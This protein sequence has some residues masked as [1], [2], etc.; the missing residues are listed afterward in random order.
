MNTLNNNGKLKIAVPNKGRLKEPTLEMLRAIGL[1][2]EV[3]ER[4]LFSRVQNFNLEILFISAG[5]I[6]EYVQDGVA[7]LG[8]TGLDLVR[9]KNARVEILEKLGYGK[10]NLTLA[11]PEGKNIRTIEDLNGKKIATTF[12]NLTKKFVEEN[13]ILA[14]IIEVDG[15]VEITP[16]LGLVDAISDLASSGSTM[17]LNKLLP[18]KTLLESEAVLIA[19]TKSLKKENPDVETLCLRFESV[20]TAR[21]KRY[22]MMNAPE[23]T[24]ETIKKI[25]PGLSSPTVM[26]L[27]QKGMIAVHSVIEK[28]EV[29]DVVEKLKKIGASGILVV[30]I[31]NMIG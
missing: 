24:L 18:L 9:E 31:E 11:V 5:N 10:A 15:A 6:P 29:W 16:W 23:D 1:D 21:N 8:I 20:I 2:F 28:K 30:P 27:S 25:A 13:K 3:T 4:Q 12:V 19:N 7:D 17:K 14:E 26:K 22:I